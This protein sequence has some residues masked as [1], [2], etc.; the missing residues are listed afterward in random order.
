MAKKNRKETPAA[1]EI[2]VEKVE[3]QKLFKH[4]ILI[5]ETEDGQ[6]N[7]TP[8]VDLVKDGIKEVDGEKVH[9]Y[10]P[11]ADEL[12]DLISETH[13]KLFALV[14]AAHVKKELASKLGGF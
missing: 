3:E 1:G 10:N 4:A 6:I 5:T 7:I 11:T 2:E 14:V 12:F 13:R 9:N 8:L